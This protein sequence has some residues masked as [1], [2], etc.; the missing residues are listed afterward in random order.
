MEVGASPSCRRGPPQAALG[1]GSPRYLRAAS[2]RPALA[3]S[4]GRPRSRRA[5]SAFPARHGPPGPPRPQTH[6]ESTAEYLGPGEI[7]A[8]LISPRL[9]PEGDPNVPFRK[10]PPALPPL[11]PAAIFLL[12]R[13]LLLTPWP[14]P[15]RCSRGMRAARREGSSHRVAGLGLDRAR[16]ALSPRRPGP[17]TKAGLSRADGRRRGPRAWAASPQAPTGGDRERRRRRRFPDPAPLGA[18]LPIHRPRRPPRSSAPLRPAAGP[19]GRRRK[20]TLARLLRPGP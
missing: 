11:L 16:G 3:F 10:T 9:S 13:R 5:R 20:G 7:P 6:P 4:P 14:A 12:P 19:R 2:R 8:S 18:R 17:H 1:L 15:P